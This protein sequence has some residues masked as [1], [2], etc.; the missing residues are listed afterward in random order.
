MSSANCKLCDKPCYVDD[1]NHFGDPCCDSCSPLLRESIQMDVQSTNDMQSYSKPN[2]FTK[3]C[4]KCFQEFK[5]P[6]YILASYQDL[7][8]SCHAQ[9]QRHHGIDN[10]DV[11]LNDQPNREEILERFKISKDTTHGPYNPKGIAKLLK[12]GYDNKNMLVFKFRCF[13]FNYYFYRVK[14]TVGLLNIILC[15]ETQLDALKYVERESLRERFFHAMEKDGTLSI[16]DRKQLFHFE[17]FWGYLN[18][19][20]NIGYLAGCMIC[21]K[22]ENED[23]TDMHTPTGFVL[24]RIM[25]IRLVQLNVLLCL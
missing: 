19:Q 13:S 2:N 18:I 8:T 15:E 7:C 17:P 5:G 24:I 11:F 6:D 12:E 9:L 4:V 16:F 10:D 23:G 20:T 3:H 25:R 22:D 21:Y 14:A 1:E